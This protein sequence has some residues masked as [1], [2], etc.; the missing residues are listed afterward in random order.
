MESTRERSP[1][2]P[3]LSL[4]A[5]VHLV[6]RLYEAE[7]RA[8]V[9]LVVVAQALSGGEATRTLS[10]PARSKIAALRA[11]GLVED[12]SAGKVRVSDRALQ[13]LQKPTPAMFHTALR[14]A[15]LA[16]PLFAELYEEHSD[17]SDGALKYY[18]M[19]ERKFTEDGANRAI[20]TYRE[21]MAYANMALG[22]FSAGSQPGIPEPEE[23][24]NTLLNK[25]SQI[26]PMWREALAGRDNSKEKVI[27]MA[28]TWPLPGGTDAQL[29]LLGN[30]PTIAAYDRLLT[31][32]TFMR[33]DAAADALR[34]N[35][36]PA[37]DA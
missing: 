13:I 5:V 17:D 23:T 21:T 15:A 33:D 11:F 12:V 34:E 26:P 36:D 2:Y 9:P 16:P 7:K 25:G 6:T 20:R 3:T 35:D 10:G 37:A 29:L 22:S 1:N 32:I 14:E 19:T 4:E 30:K 8:T 28:Y 31:L 18:L 27:H 24:P